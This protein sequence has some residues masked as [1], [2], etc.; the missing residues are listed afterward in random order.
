MLNRVGAF[1]T[2]C[3][4]LSGGIIA[5]ALDASAE[6]RA[7]AAATAPHGTPYVDVA[8]SHDVTNCALVLAAT[9]SPS[10]PGCGA[11]ISRVLESLSPPVSRESNPDV[12]SPLFLLPP[13]RAPPRA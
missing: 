3:A 10:L 11:G 4:L 5:P 8:P 6:H 2:L 7:V 13:S 9:V 12:P 1:L